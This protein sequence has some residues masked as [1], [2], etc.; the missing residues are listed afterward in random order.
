[1]NIVLVFSS[2]SPYHHARALALRRACGEKGY[3]LIIAAM[4]APSLSH[5]WTPDTDSD[6][7]V[8]CSSGSD[9]NVSLRELL[10]AWMRFLKVHRPAV[11]VIAGYW[12]FSITLLSLVAIAKGIPR[13]LMTESHAA[14]AKETGFAAFAKRL[15]VSSYS[16][17][18]VGGKPHAEYLLSLGFSSAR[19]RDGY[20][21]VENDFFAKEA[22]VIR[23]QADKFRDRYRLPENFFLSVARLVP[24]K[25]IGTLITAYVEYCSRVCEKALDLVIVGDGELAAELRQQCAALGHPVR[26]ASHEKFTAETPPLSLVGPLEKP[27]VHFYG[28]R[29][30]NEL[31]AFFALARAFVLPS[32]EEE[33]GLVVNEAMASGCPVIVSE[34]AGC[35]Q[36]LLPEVFAGESQSYCS[37][38][39]VKL[40]SSG[41]LFDPERVEDLVHALK[42]MTFARELRESMVANAGSVVERYSPR[43]FA[44]NVLELAELVTD[45][46]TR[47]SPTSGIVNKGP[48]IASSISPANKGVGRGVLE[49]LR[50][51]AGGFGRSIARW[52]SRNVRGVSC[53]TFA[54][55]R[56]RQQPLHQRPDAWSSR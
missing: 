23:G 22:A 44:E 27:K 55:G 18:L 9:G 39:Q 51:L 26:D 17:A 24:K 52:R 46:V 35:A 43:H 54:G 4:T 48:A 14:T 6:L 1:M 49:R 42:M 30:I 29:R 41:V 5:Q 15:L 56:A 38:Q 25:N 37:G 2:F 11:V 20:D 19:I 40:R 13:I 53:A 36:D 34:R 10:C 21:C 3:R 16:A 33:W 32:I 12:P 31:P 50:G 28:A 8:L 45:D 7:H 47:L